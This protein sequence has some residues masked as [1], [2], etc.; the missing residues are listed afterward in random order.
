MNNGR[1]S[2]DCSIDLYSQSIVITRY[3]ADG[4]VR[5]RFADADQLS[6]MLNGLR[7]SQPQWF[8]LDD[9]VQAVGLDGQGNQLH[10]LVRKAKSTY[11]NIEIGRKNYK[12]R[13]MMPALL[14]ML[15]ANYENDQRIWTGVKKV[16]AFAG[17]SL[18]PKTQLYL[19]PLPN[20]YADGKVCM[21]NVNFKAFNKLSASEFFEQAF[22]RSVFTDHLMDN[23]LESNKKWRNV[24]VALRDSNGKVPFKSL[25]KVMKYEELC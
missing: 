9:N 12:M 8:K 6:A 17:K 21:G 5:R 20:M 19:P 13:I 1:Q 23:A 3:M 10:I 25:K 4:K 11:I 16:F 2:L 24:F 18:K 7:S 15:E 14:A 22:I